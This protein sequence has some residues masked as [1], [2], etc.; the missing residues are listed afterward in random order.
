MVNAFIQDLRYGLRVL[1]KSPGFMVVAVLSL[2]LGIGAN[3]AIFSV[4]HAVLLR[5][6][7]Y[8]DPE[9]LV[10][11]WETSARQ[12]FGRMEASYPN[13]LDWRD[14]SRAF[15]DLAG[16][17]GA[18]FTVQAGEAP[19]RISASR[20][21]PNFF[22][23]LGVKPVLGRD[24]LPGEELPGH[25]VVLLSHGYWRRRFGGDPRSSGARSAWTARLTPW[26]ASCRRSSISR[27]AAAPMPG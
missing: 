21:T 23:L 20:V 26:W 25:R 12:D 7:P 10:H 11:L 27:C 14:G 3:T 15:T 2:A 22:S 24:F 4:V 18:G 13:Y 1:A 6:L 8:A 19:E 16:Y 5:P 9:R 17:A